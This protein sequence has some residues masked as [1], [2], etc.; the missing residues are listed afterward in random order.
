MTPLEQRL[1]ATPRR[2]IPAEFRARIL[3]AAQPHPSVPAFLLSLAKSVFS[4][5]HPIAWGAVAAGWIAIVALNFSGPRGEA[6]YAV[7]PKDYKG[8]LPSAREYLVQMDLQ[9]R[10]LI[11][12][13]AEDL[14]PRPAYY[15]RP[16]DL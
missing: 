16:Q 1:S 8:R 6:L 2:E 4:F 12:L 11:A 9:R 5:P 13:A 3:A 7:T 10:F 14:E 15:L